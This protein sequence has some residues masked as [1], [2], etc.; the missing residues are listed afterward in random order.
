VEEFLDV[1]QRQT[2]I[3]PCL[4]GDTYIRRVRLSL[5]LPAKTDLFPF[6][7]PCPDCLPGADRS[8]YCKGGNYGCCCS[9][10]NS[11]P[12]HSL[13]KLSFIDSAGIDLCIAE[14]TSTGE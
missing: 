8:R 3:I 14:F 5:R 6:S 13:L 12:A 1:L 11:V 10:N 2:P 9:K 7:T 4:F